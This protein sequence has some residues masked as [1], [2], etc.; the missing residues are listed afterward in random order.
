MKTRSFILLL[1]LITGG[2][3][4]CHSASSES[5]A[6]AEMEAVLSFDGMVKQS[7]DAFDEVFVAPDF[8]LQDYDSVLLESGRVAFKKNWAR[9][10]NSGRA[11]RVNERDLQN[12]RERMAGLLMSEFESVLEEKGV[13]PLVAEPGLRTLLVKPSIINLDVNAPDINTASRQYSYAE[14]AGEA[15]LFLELFDS[16]SGKPL[17]R[18]V[19]RQVDRDDN[20]FTLRTRASNAQDAKRISR[21]W[22]ERLVEL[23]TKVEP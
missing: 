5:T 23:M 11:N 19:D 15:T 13:M 17:A 1:L 10:Y 4:G 6:V 9:D 21:A 22:A 18:V 7:Q 14:S 12:I 8:S 20:Y 2:L 16:V 3:T